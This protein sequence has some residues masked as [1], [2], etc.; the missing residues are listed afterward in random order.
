M[1]SLFQKSHLKLG[2]AAAGLLVGISS[3]NAKP[4]DVEYSIRV[5]GL[6]IGN[7]RL[8]GDVSKSK[9][10]LRGDIVLKGIARRLAGEGGYA[11]SVGIVTK[12]SLRPRNFSWRFSGRKGESQVAVRYARGNAQKVVAKLPPAYSDD[13]VMLK[14]QHKRGVVDPFSAL[15]LPYQEK[16]EA[17]CKGS[18]ALFNGVSRFKISLS[19]RG[20]DGDMIVCNF[21]YRPIAGHPRRIDPDKA[22]RRKNTVWFKRIGGVYLPAKAVMEGRL[23]NV[24]IETVGR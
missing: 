16:P 24:T 23:G 21:S 5:F 10:R 13:R 12:R 14:D 20:Q 8:K 18:R 15:A 6:T 1:K 9:Y 19:Y 17:V 11:E 4:I 3:T 2:A 7:A 22:E